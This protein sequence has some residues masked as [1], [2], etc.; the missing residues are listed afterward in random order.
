M[1]LNDAKPGDVV[2]LRST[3]IARDHQVI[4]T[5]YDLIDVFVGAPDSLI[6][7]CNLRLE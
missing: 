1:A 7:R 4:G 5:R 6:Q 2:D 3:R